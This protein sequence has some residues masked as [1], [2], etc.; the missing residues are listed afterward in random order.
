M[1]RKVV[2]RTNND[3][4]GYEG[5]NSRNWYGEDDYEVGQRVMGKEVSLIGKIYDEQ[6][7]QCSIGVFV[8]VGENRKLYCEI[9]MTSVARI[10]YS[11]EDDTV[12]E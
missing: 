6:N 8:G 1:I 2:Y 9:P 4:C 12:S 10:Y 5:E 7:A 11:L 3:T